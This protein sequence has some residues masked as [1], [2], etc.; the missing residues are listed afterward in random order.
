MHG[1]GKLFKIKRS[2]CNISIET[3]NIWN[4]LPRPAVSNELIAVIN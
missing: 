1:K 4:T 2:I 3:A